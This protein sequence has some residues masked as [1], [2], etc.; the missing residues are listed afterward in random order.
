MKRLFEAIINLVYPPEPGDPPVSWWWA[1]LLLVLL[2]LF[3]IL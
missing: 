1:L 2:A 3:V